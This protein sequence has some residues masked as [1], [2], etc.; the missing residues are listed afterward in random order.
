MS[1]ELSSKNHVRQ[2]LADHGLYAKKHFGQNF[3][4]DSHVLSKIV[5]GAD[6]SEGDTVIEVGPG[7]GV[8]T[9]ELAGRASRVIAVEIDQDLAQILTATMPDNVTVIREDI[10]KLDVRHAVGASPLASN[11]IKVVANLPYYITSAVIFGLLEQ[12]LPIKTMVVMVQKEVA[13]RFLAKP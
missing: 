11:N 7:L 2:L 9:T 8:L 10:L 12:G 4:T 1:N 5:D 6:L 13:D 3:L